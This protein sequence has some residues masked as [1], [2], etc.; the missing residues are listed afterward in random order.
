MKTIIRKK[1]TNVYRWHLMDHDSTIESGNHVGPLTDLTRLLK[2]KRTE[3][4][5]RK[6]ARE[7]EAARKRAEAAAAN[8]RAFDCRR[9]GGRPRNP[10]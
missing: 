4:Y 10:L 7:A 9:R 6:K 5:A 1:G 8:P 3:Y 2:G